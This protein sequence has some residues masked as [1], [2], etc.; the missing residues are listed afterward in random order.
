MGTSTTLHV[1]PSE[2]EKFKAIYKGPVVP[3]SDSD[4]PE[5][6]RTVDEIDSNTD[7]SRY[8][9]LQGRKVQGQPTRGIYIKGGKKVIVKGE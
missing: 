1:L 6:I 3:L 9:D 5:G 7:A 2:V 4:Q 8:N